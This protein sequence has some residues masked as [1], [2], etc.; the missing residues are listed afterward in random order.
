MTRYAGEGAAVVCTA[1]GCADS[2]ARWAAYHLAAGF[3]Q[4]H[5][6]MDD[7]GEA[8]DAAARMRARGVRAAVVGAASTAPTIADVLVV[9]CDAEL[10][11][12]WRA[13]PNYARLAAYC[14]LKVRRIRR[15]VRRRAG[16]LMHVIGLLTVTHD[17]TYQPPGHRLPIP[18]LGQADGR[19]AE[20][21]QARQELNA[22]HA[23][24]RALC[25]GRDWLLHIDADELFY[26]ADA[27][28]LGVGGN[29]RNGGAGARSSDSSPVAAHFAALSAAGVT[30]YVYKN[31]EGVPEVL[32]TDA[33]G[34]DGD[35]DFFDA[36]TLFR[37]SPGDV[38]G[39]QVGVG[40]SSPLD[41]KRLQRV[42]YWRARTPHRQF[43]L[44]YDNGKA[45]V[46]LADGVVP[47][48]V[49]EWLPP[50]AEDLVRGAVRA[51]S[52]AVLPA[53]CRPCSLLIIGNVAAPCWTQ[54]ADPQCAPSPPPRPRAVRTAQRPRPRHRRRPAVRPCGG[55]WRAMR[56]ALHRLW[57][58]VVRAPS[59]SLA[60]RP[61]CALTRTSTRVRVPR[62]RPPCC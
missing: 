26:I 9:P 17:F 49:H 59:R 22:A 42:E 51:H 24:K 29:G 23:A 28:A 48:S 57:L 33:N 56:A 14:E 62:V 36:V 31:L 32:A 34:G 39:T 38:Y 6:Y 2:L 11:H 8:A 55:R 16:V 37:R 10:R 40:G 41:A 61:F 52:R 45:A 46:R 35:G 3:A 30:T 27:A 25:M 53:L 47:L 43:F 58:R 5:C 15:P 1:R 7:P 50:S 20:E 13:L 21:V 54:R 12:E 60:S 19:R 44:G 18:H 4:C